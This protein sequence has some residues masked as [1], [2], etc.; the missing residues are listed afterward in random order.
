M[1]GTVGGNYSAIPR[2]QNWSL[3]LLSII[4]VLGIWE[5]GGR[6]LH[7]LLFPTPLQAFGALAE[8]VVQ[9][10][11]WGAFGLSNQALLFGFSSGAVVGI[12]LGLG[13]GRSQ[14]LEKIANPYLNIMLATPMSALIPILILAAGFGLFSRSLV[15]FIFCVV[16]ITV[17]ARTGL[18]TLDPAWVEMAR[19]F[20]ASEFEIWRKILIPGALPAIVTGLRLGLGRALTGMVAVELTLVAVGI[21]RLILDFQGMFEAG[22]VYATIMVVMAEALLLL[23]LL[24]WLERRVAPWNATVRE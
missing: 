4:V 3:R 12:L 20:G 6:A 9:P 24:R 2:L 19:T 7:S 21:G 8:L 1:T 17:N 23:S 11:F 14:T 18:R 16:V 22:H 15:V 10:S 5:I 13:M